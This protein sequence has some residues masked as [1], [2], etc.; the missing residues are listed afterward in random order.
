[1]QV[2][3][4]SATPRFTP[5]STFHHPHQT[6][7]SYNPPP[8]P[9]ALYSSS[10][11]NFPILSSPIPKKEAMPP[12]QATPPPPGVYVPVPTF[13]SSASKDEAEASQVSKLY[14]NRIDTSTQISHTLHLASS[15][16]TGVVLLGSTGESIHLSP[17][18]RLTLISSTR[19]ALDSAGHKKY[20]IIVGVLTNSIEDAIDQLSDAKA[21]GGDFGLV[22]A[23]GYF[24]R[25]VSQEGIVEW[26]RA[27]A[28]ASELPILL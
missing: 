20:P 3:G 5:P 24:G 4:P 2:R 19:T 6:Q 27:V 11:P 23:P 8:L 1:M 14:K 22:L 15:G 26:Y 25:G 12:P 21:A 28:D 10:Y 18:E 16:I 9:S 7:T 17:T 13:F